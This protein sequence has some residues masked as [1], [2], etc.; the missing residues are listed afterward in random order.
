MCHVKKCNWG[1]KSLPYIES[2]LLKRWRWRLAQPQKMLSPQRRSFPHSGASLLLSQVSLGRATRCQ[3]SSF[4]FGLETGGI[5]VLFTYVWKP[6]T[7]KA[8][9]NQYEFIPSKHLIPCAF[10]SSCSI[11]LLENWPSSF[12]EAF[13]SFTFYCVHTYWLQARLWQTMSIQFKDTFQI[14]LTQAWQKN[15]SYSKQ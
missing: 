13:I 2:K 7:N 12:P 8:S 1:R 5:S 3:Q 6:D 11:C 9:P 14:R 4:T 15:V 10:F